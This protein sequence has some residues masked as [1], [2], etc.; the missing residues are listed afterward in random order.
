VRVALA[1]VDSIRPSPV[2]QM[3]AGLFNTLNPTELRDLVGYIMSGGDPND[4]LY[5]TKKKKK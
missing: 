1:D 5:R 2:S 3:P 4:K